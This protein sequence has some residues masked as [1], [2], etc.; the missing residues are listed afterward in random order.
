MGAADVAGFIERYAELL[1]SGEPILVTGKVS[2]PQ[3]DESGDEV[4]T[5][6]RE[7][8]VLLDEA[9]PLS[10]AIRAETRSV[11]IRLRESTTRKEHIQEL[12]KVLRGSPGGCPV[13][14]I[15]ETDDGAEAVLALGRDLGV[16]PADAMVASL[17]RLFGM[18]V[19]ELR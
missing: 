4:D 2:F 13:Q 17:E 18:K 8:T 12:Q 1:T 16:E 9:V 7:P 15:I 14:L 19:A 10:D 6:P 5:G 3:E 11:T